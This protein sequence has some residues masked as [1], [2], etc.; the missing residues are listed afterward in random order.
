MSWE[1]VESDYWGFTCLVD[2]NG[3]DILILDG[4]NDGDFPICWMGE[5]MSDHVRRL[6]EVSPDLLALCR[7]AE[8]LSGD[9][10]GRILM[11]GPNGNGILVDEIITLR[12]DIHDVISQIPEAS[13]E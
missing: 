6:I 3:N 1:F 12:A 2:Q 8:E 11:L 10:A 4:Q 7:R 5:D 9:A 13:D